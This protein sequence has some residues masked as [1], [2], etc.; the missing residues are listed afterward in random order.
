MFECFSK[1][2]FIIESGSGVFA[3][4]QVRIRIRFS[5]ISGFGF[6]TRIPDPDSRQRKVQ[7]ALN[8][9]IRRFKKIHLRRL[10]GPSKNEKGSN[11]LLKI[12]I[13]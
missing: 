9:F 6:S 12:I 10:L 1:V 11:F 4:I 7:S 3:W 5:N 8:L 2:W 13:K